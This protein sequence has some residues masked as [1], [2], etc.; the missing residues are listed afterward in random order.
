MPNSSYHQVV[1]LVAS[2]LAISS[3]SSFA[4]DADCGEGYTGY[5]LKLG[6]E[7]RSYV[8]CSS[9]RVISTTLCPGS[10]I[11]DGSVG[12]GGVCGWPSTVTCADDGGAAVS[13]VAA[14]ISVDTNEANTLA[15]L[16]H[17]NPPPSPP[18]TND[19]VVEAPTPPTVDT[20]ASMNLAIDLSR[21][22]PGYCGGSRSDAEA[23]CVPCV[24]RMCNE[25]TE[26][27][28]M[29]T[30][31]ISSN[32]VSQPSPAATASFSVQTPPSSTSQ[33]VPPP[34]TTAT[35]ESTVVDTTSVPTTSPS[36]PPWTNA[37]FTPYNGPRRDKTVIGYYASWQW[38][39][40]AKFADPPNIDWRK[41]DRINYA[42][43]QI[44]KEG[45]I[46]G[47]DEWADPQLLWGPYIW[48][49]A[50]QIETGPGANYFCSWDG[51]IKRNCNF[52]DTSK[53]IIEL[54]HRAGATVMPSIGGWTLSDNFPIVAASDR[55]RKNFARN[56]V[57]LIEQYG[58]DGLDI[59]WEYP[60]YK[61]HSGTDQDKFTFTL[62]LAEIRKQLDQLG[63]IKGKYY[64]LTAA[65]PCGP[66][67]IANIQIDQIK[68]ILDELNL[69]TY[70]LHGAWDLLT[71]TN[72]PMTDQGW[73][74]V[75]KRWSVHGCT[76]TYAE[77]GVPLSK[78]NLGLPFYGRSFRRA[79]GM[80]QLHEGADDINFHLDEG[81]PQYFNIVKDLK[82]MTTYRHEKTQT[83]YTVFNSPNGGLVSYDDPRAICDKVHYANG[84][85]LNG[86]LVW[87][88]SGDMLE[89][90]QT[91]L[92]DATNDKINDPNLDCSKLR[93]PMWSL[94]SSTYFYA[95]DEPDKVDMSNA[96]SFSLQGT[97]S[98]NDFNGAQDTGLARPA[99]LSTSDSGTST[100]NQ[101]YSVGNGSSSSSTVKLVKDCPNGYTGY[102]TS[103]DCTRYFQCSDG[104]ILGASLPCVPG[105]L[106][107]VHINTCAFAANVQC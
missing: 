85:G 50:R 56:C 13:S 78:I 29:G 49:T 101:V 96:A 6:T 55:T 69:M 88:I 25:F 77:F 90:G 30:S 35:T 75:T 8:Y 46:Y 83:Q 7:C 22:D 44:D 102:W 52:H 14:S 93:D 34:S 16:I 89:N 20:P 71:G 104:E 42:F 81:S 39:D 63:S 80:K 19:A 97:G 51:P 100:R 70:D 10:T 95:P 24:E 41:Y 66:D 68:D 33:Y 36:L 65:L 3:S 53:G 40:R 105:T 31:C 98:T 79:T 15:Q 26:A 28:W 32:N 82:R 74:D 72:A 62:L 38:Y 12:V 91:P 103:V 87:E 47:T 73:T 2:L 84:R 37:P 57:K 23:K 4:F 64:K 11:Y 45:A 9:G 86:F 67:K 43:F 1:I 48:D 17:N 61:P 76:N 99:S 59:D 107:D 94:S 27:C 5:S 21:S 54:A 18:T 106:F 60:G 58:F 92:I